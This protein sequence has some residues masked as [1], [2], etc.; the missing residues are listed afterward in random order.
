MSRRAAWLR[1]VVVSLAWLPLVVNAASVAIDLNAFHADPDVLVAGD[2]S[3]ATFQESAFVSVLRLVNDPFLGDAEVL[4]AAAGRALEFDYSFIEASDGEDE[5]SAVLFDADRGPLAGVLATQTFASTASGSA[6]FDLSPYVGLRLGLE[7]ALIDLDPHGA[8]GSTAVVSNLAL[9]TPVPLHGTLPL[10]GCALG[11]VVV[12]RRYG[13]R[14]ARRY[15]VCDAALSD[16]VPTATS[17]R[18]LASFLI[19]LEVLMVPA[20]RNAS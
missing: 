3:S 7:F 13:A 4:V 17:G 15:R 18:L 20:L 12:R 11:I 8:L 5:F 2:G 1:P 6:K 9:A 10:F 19:T 14:A 16:T